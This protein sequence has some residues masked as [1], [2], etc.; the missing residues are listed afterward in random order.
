MSTLIKPN[1]L[2]SVY[3]WSTSKSN[4][5]TNLI[6]KNTKITPQS[7]WPH[8]RLLFV[9]GIRNYKY[10]GTRTPRPRQNLQIIQTFVQ[11]Q[12]QTRT[13]CV[14]A[15][16]VEENRLWGVSILIHFAGPPCYFV[17][18]YSAPSV[19]ERRYL[20]AR[21]TIRLWVTPHLRYYDKACWSLG[22]LAEWRSYRL[23]IQ[24][25]NPI[26]KHDFWFV[27]RVTFILVTLHKVSDLNRVSTVMVT[28]LVRSKDS[29][30]LFRLLSKYL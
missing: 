9:V 26:S 25:K 12:E 4:C 24:C 7:H 16:V 22:L 17:S 19:C 5:F 14:V 21:C 27:R 23:K 20:G 13:T 11:P 3:I 30:S 10:H 29:V 18:G 1:R 28:E 6:K 2:H 15:N 8:T